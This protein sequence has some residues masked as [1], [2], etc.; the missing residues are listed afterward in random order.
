MTRRERAAV[1]RRLAKLFAAA[2]PAT[3]T[4]PLRTVSAWD[5]CRMVQ[6]QTGC[7]YEQADEITQL[8]APTLY[9]WEVM[10]KPKTKRTPSLHEARKAHAEAR[11]RVERAREILI[12]TVK[13]LT[14]IPAS[15]S[16]GE[17]FDIAFAAEVSTDKAGDLLAE[18]MDKAGEALEKIP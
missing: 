13:T 5:F 2:I 18:A 1:G 6:E 3:K 14:R 12:K 15:K 11:A 4:E 9:A 17:L 16:S 7:T 8:V 10:P